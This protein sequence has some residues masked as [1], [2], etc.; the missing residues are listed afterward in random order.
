MKRIKIDLPPDL[1]GNPRGKLV[2]H[3]DEGPPE[4]RFNIG[5]FI[6]VQ[7]Q[8]Y[9]VIYMYRLVSS[10]MTWQ[11]VL[12]ER[13]SPYSQ[14]DDDLWFHLTQSCCLGRH[15]P[16]V[17]PFLFKKMLHA[18]AFFRDVP[19]FSYT[20]EFDG[21]TLRETGAI[22]SSGEVVDDPIMD[23]RA[24]LERMALSHP[25]ITMRIVKRTLPL[26]AALEEFR[27]FELARE[28]LFRDSSEDLPDDLRGVVNEVNA[29][30]RG[31]N[32]RI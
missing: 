22:I 31:T 20:L 25:E 17:P 7:G 10:P 1:L 19:H 13:R 24:T 26:Q 21:P 18:I 4:P 15:I 14:V 8:L 5:N 27:A 30:L 29:F 12:E 32:I 3:L 9:E 28:E 6:L 11:Y 23:L 2:V 16:R